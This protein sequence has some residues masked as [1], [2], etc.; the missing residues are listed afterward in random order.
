MLTGIDNTGY[1]EFVAF[2]RINIGKKAK[3]NKSAFIE[4]LKITTCYHQ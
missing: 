3:D 4:L 2:E 1:V